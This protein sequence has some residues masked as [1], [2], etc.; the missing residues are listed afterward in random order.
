L[1]KSA[2]DGGCIRPRILSRGERDDVLWEGPVIVGSEKVVDS[3][4]IDLTTTNWADRKLVLQIDAVLT[5][6]P[7]GADPLDIRDHAN[8][9]DPVLQFDTAF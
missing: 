8:W 6:Q 5:G 3:G 7:R 1:D 4:V 9:C 2:E